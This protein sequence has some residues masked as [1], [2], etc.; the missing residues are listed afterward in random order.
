MRLIFAVPTQRIVQFL[1]DSPMPF[2]LCVFAPLREIFLSLVA[3][4]PRYAFG[5]LREI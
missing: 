3:A 4:S 1:E 2:Y 5:S